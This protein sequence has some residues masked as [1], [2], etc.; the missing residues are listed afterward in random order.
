MNKD[1]LTADIIFDSRVSVLQDR[2]G[3]RFSIDAVILAWHA[4]LRPAKTVLDLGTGCGIIPLVM[5]FRNPGMKITGIEIQKELADIAALNVRENGMED[6]IAVCRKDMKELNRNFAEAF[7]LVISNPPYRKVRSGRINP[8]RQRALARHEIMAGLPDV[9]GAAERMLDIS[10]R[11]IIIYLAERTAGLLARMRSF[12]IEPK[13]FRTIHPRCGDEAK[14]IL[15]E[16][17]KGG[18]PGLKI[19][20]PL[21]IYRED[22]SYTDE[23]EIMYA[24]G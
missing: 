9:L 12:N 20:S 19:G 22:G 16:G 14:L 13:F 6:R 7:E 4:G 8:N 2:D 15:V 10:G 18:R 21:F 24:A 11:F 1:N 5:A 23:M 3:Y 17:V